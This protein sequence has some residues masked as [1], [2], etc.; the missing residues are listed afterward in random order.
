MFHACSRRRAHSL[1]SQ[2]FVSARGEGAGPRGISA[3]QG[4]ET[5]PGY[6][7]P[8]TWP[9]R[10]TPSRG[11][12]PGH[13]QA[14]AEGNA[15]VVKVVK[16]FSREH[17]LRVSKSHLAELLRVSGLKESLRMVCVFLLLGVAVDNVRLWSTGPRYGSKYSQVTD[18]VHYRQSAISNTGLILLWQAVFIPIYECV[19]SARRS[20]R[21]VS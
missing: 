7:P 9:V 18:R 16:R 19:W 6:L 17:F 13:Q 3:D 11:L 4:W 12:H 20:C 10:R 14:D 8:R 1:P 15:R 5:C 2:V 21:C